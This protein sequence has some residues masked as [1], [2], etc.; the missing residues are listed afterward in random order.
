V[1]SCQPAWPNRVYRCNRSM[2]CCLDPIP[3]PARQRP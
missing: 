3:W 1:V 2:Q